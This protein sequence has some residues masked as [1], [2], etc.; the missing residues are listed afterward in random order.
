MDAI[1][2]FRDADE[3]AAAACRHVTQT[4]EKC[5]VQRGVFNLV[6]TGG[7]TPRR[8]YELLSQRTEVDWQKWHFFMGDERY[9]PLDDERSNQKMAQDSLLSRLPLDSRQI[10]AVPV[11]EPTAYQAAALYEKLILEYFGI[12][13]TDP[14]PAFDLILLG[15][16]SDGHTASLFPGKP[17][18]QETK[19][20]VVSSEPGALPP[21]VDRVTFTFPL[22]NAAGAVLFVAAGA[23]KAGAFAKVR[24][25][26]A[27][28]PQDAETPAGKVRPAAGEL[29]WYVD[30]TIIN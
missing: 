16:G 30:R 29:L 26:L 21:P 23:D 12:G 20:L 18:P 14:V 15:M 17:A 28:K 25:D 4:A 1:K 6:L 22:I 9:V 13:Q 10:H 3:I 24:R 5:I 7:S 19:K 11:G 27:Q 8:L 2:V